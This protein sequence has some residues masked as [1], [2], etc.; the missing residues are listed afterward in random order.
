MAVLRLRT[1]PAETLIGV[2]DTSFMP[3]R[4][5]HS[6]G[7]DKFFSHAAKAMRTGLELSLLT[8]IATHSRRTIALDATQ[9]SPS[10][11]KSS[12][13]PGYS[14][15]DFYLEQITDLLEPFS[16]H[17]IHS[18]STFH[19]SAKSFFVTPRIIL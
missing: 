10:L 4:G 18:F 16:H 17:S 9:T 13:G 14:R 2:F 6:W 1:H 3:K 7:L 8:V 11:S 15:I 19:S 12:T 5:S